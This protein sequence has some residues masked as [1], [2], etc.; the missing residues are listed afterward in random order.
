MAKNAVRTQLLVYAHWQGMAE[1]QWM[2]TLSATPGRGKEI[3]SFEYSRDW[4]AS[5]YAQ[6]LDPDLQ[7]Y[8]GP[9]YLAKDDQSNFG[10]FL[11]SAPDRWGRLLMRRREA[12]LARQEA[13]S[14]RTLMES[15]YLLGVFDGHRM[16]GLRFK[17]QPDGPFL[18]DNRA[19]AA[20]P[21]TSLRELEH[22]SL[23]LERTDAASD[24]DY[25]KWLALLV[26][27]G[28]SLG[29]ARPKASVVDQHNALWIAKFPSS[30]DEHDVGAWEALVNRLAVKAGM[31]V[32]DGRAQQFNSRH[33]TYLS[34]R[35]DR[36]ADGQ[37]LHFASAMTLLGYQDGTSYQDGASYLELA[38]LLITQGASTGP[39]LAELWR[40]IVFNICI[41]NTDDHLR[42]HGFLLTP[43]GW[44]LAPAYDLNPIP[45]GHGLR[46]NISETS[47]E[48]DL[49]L[50][51]SVAPHFRLKPAQATALLTEVL[52]AVRTW[53][54]EAETHQLS[55]E[56]QQR[57]SRAFAAAE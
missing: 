9:Q 40:R 48:L 19:M 24:P 39:D 43:Q 16:G 28:S 20:P 15:D 6:L 51:C 27:P 49:E 12:A 44:R 57:M 13:R 2:G 7:L 54:Q 5:P 1:P 14:E 41:S 30:H 17:T 56:E 32:A 29:G 42:N 37:R 33:H 25:L 50:A 34:R 10:L 55:R 22:A 46:L 45:Y 3:F 18:N 47:N 53:P 21:W 38:E 23:Q 52:A 11:D 4:L 8:S 26:A 31:H 35:F 36:S